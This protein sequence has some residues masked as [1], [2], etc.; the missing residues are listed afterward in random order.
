MVCTGRKTL[1]EDIPKLII[2][3]KADKK[4]LTDLT[5]II[6]KIKST[7]DIKGVR[8]IDVFAFTCKQDQ[9]ED[10]ELNAF[11][12]EDT[13]KIKQQIE[14]W[15]NLTLQGILKYC[16]YAARNFMKMKLMKKAA[17]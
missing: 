5:D 6:A 10:P 9:I 4:S 16:L 12:E 13:K 14:I 15:N 1:R 7:L 2:L 8:Y 3:N 17:N 11:I